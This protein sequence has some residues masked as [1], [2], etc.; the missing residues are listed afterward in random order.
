MTSCAEDIILSNGTPSQELK[1]LM[2]G[3]VAVT[4]SLGLCVL[5]KPVILDV[6]VRIVEG[7]TETVWRSS[8]AFL[9]KG[10]GVGVGLMIVATKKDAT[11]PEHNSLS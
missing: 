11:G 7:L 1:E 6:M 4:V 2:R 3:K 5:V 9:P 8:S 10:F